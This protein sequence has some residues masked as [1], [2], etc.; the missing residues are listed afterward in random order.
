MLSTCCKCCGPVEDLLKR[1]QFYLYKKFTTS[2]SLVHYC[3]RRVVDLL[4]SDFHIKLKSSHNKNTAHT[5][6]SQHVHNYMETRLYCF[7]SILILATIFGSVSAATDLYQMRPQLLFHTEKLENSLLLAFE[8]ESNI[9]I[10]S[11]K[12]LSVQQF[13]KSFHLGNQ[14]SVRPQ[15]QTVL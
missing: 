5:R 10:C 2:P 12:P 6:S 11:Q 1:E 13:L 4:W 9:M 14:N 15:F 7:G 3:R 8:I